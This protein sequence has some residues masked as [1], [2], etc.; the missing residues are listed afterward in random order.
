MGAPAEAATCT[1]GWKHTATNI[2]N[3]AQF[4]ATSTCDGAYAGTTGAIS[5]YVRGRF[6][7]DGSWQ[8]STYGY[9]WVSSA[10]DGWDK[11]IGNMVSGRAIRG[12]SYTYNQGVSYLY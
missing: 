12:Q 11:V 8:T 2:S 10:N 5:D 9:V 1:A 4:S 6:H 3:S 7:K